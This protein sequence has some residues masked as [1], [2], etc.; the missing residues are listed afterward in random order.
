M[1]KIKK[2]KKRK[3][4]IKIKL[5][6]FSYYQY[7][8]CFLYFLYFLCLCLFTS[9]CQAKNLGVYGVTFEIIEKDFKEFI[10]E[11]LHQLQQNGMLDKFNKK[12]LSNVK[13]HTLRPT[14]VKGLTTTDNPQTFY[15]DPTYVLK[16][17]IRN[18]NGKI[19][20]PKGTTINPFDVIKLHSV[21]LVFNADDKRQLQWAREIAK[22]HDYTKYI[23][24]QGNIKDTS[25]T[26]KDRVYF[27]QYGAITKQLD[28][29]HI[30]C[31]VRQKNKKL[32]ITEF[33]LI[34]SQINKE[35]DKSISNST[36]NNN[37]S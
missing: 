10:Y 31:L 29:K 15:Y 22:K 17:D 23:L 34:L 26:L 13:N 3:R 8:L 24:V 32:Q 1:E 4:K 11:R 12:F 9:T 28:I 5:L 6:W 16:E 27:D 18:A 25:N 20:T 7:F 36:S 19:L 35:N 14:P 21:W 30:P 2:A 37:N 33:S